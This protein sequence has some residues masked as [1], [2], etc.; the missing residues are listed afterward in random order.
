MVNTTEGTEAT[1]DAKG[2][3]ATKG[4]EDT[5]LMERA[6]F[7][8]E[9]GRGRT[10]PNPLVGAVVVTPDGVVVGQGAHIAAGGP[11]AEV[12]A[13]DHAGSRAQGATLYCTLE[14]CSHVGRTGPCVERIVAAG[15]ARV[16]AA[17]TDPNPRVSGKG[18]AF[19]RERGIEVVEDVAQDEAARQ[20]AAFLMWIAHGR[21]LVTLK[22]AVSADGFVGA[23]DRRVRLTGPAANRFLQRERAEFDAIAVGSGTVLTDD[24]LLTARVAYR[25]RPLTRVIFDWRARVPVTA[26]VFS[27][28]GE[29][30]VIMIVSAGAAEARRREL[31]QLE[32]RGVAV[33]TF[34]QVA[35]GPVVDW[36]GTREILSLLVEGGP[37]LHDRFL[38]AGL[39]DRVQWVVTPGRLEQGVPIGGWSRGA[40]WSALPRTRVLGED[41]LIEFD[42]HRP[43]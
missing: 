12:V 27:T 3:E 7:L 8:A 1:E 5:K 18:F 2:V 35:L 9:R 29:G 20:N 14:P 34:P 26:R 16:V 21:P 25:Y 43:H 31:D 4:T 32:A 17:V 36:L 28:L 24:P 40:L 42:V 15:I 6:L 41:T 33:Q 10:T 37:A 30:P 11:H 13:L 23:R 19:L 22:A 39:A 38:E